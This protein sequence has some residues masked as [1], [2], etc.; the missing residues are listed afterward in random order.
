M[1]TSEPPLDLDELYVFAVQLGKDAGAL[2]LDAAEKRCEASPS[3]EK[4]QQPEATQY[5]Q[6]DNAVDLVTQ[7]DEGRRV[8][9]CLV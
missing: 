3:S 5:V 9:P 8:L 2:L 7:A 4:E 6:K 1:E